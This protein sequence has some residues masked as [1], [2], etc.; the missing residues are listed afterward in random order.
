MLINKVLKQ[1]RNKS[2]HETRVA[3]SKIEYSGTRLLNN[4]EH[5]HTTGCALTL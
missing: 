3:N 5:T 4:I 1:T 2:K